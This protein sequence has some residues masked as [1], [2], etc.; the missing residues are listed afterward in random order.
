MH[1]QV[2]ESL[3]RERDLAQKYLDSVGVIILTLDAT[4]EITFINQRG[5]DVLGYKEEELIGK[6]WFD[7][8][9]PIDAREEVEGA[10]GR[11]MAGEVEPSAYDESM[12]ITKTG[13]RRIIAWHNTVLA[14]EAGQPIG[15]LRSGE[16]VTERK[17]LEREIA[18]RAEELA[19]SNTELEQFASIASHDLQEPLRMV[20]S[21]LQ[22][23]E[24]RYKGKLDSDADDFIAYAVD[25][26]NRMQA[27][28]NDLL[29]Y[30]RV[31][32]Q[33]K[34]PEPTDCNE[35]LNRV[36]INLRVVI[37]ESGAVVSR[38]ELPVI[39]ADDVQIGQVFQNLVG[40]AIKFRSDEPLRIH[41]GVKR[42][43][44]YWLFSVD[45][46]GV[47]IDQ[48][49]ADRIFRIFQRL[50]TREEYP[51]TGIGLAVC[52]RIVE[53]HGGHIWLKAKS[54]RGSTFCFTIPDKEN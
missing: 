1:K 4:G 18:R 37:E 45:D 21:F 43:N 31:D 41:V 44:G 24:Q 16:D 33:G 47:G 20:A 30:S 17:Q 2:E 52:K 19:R 35:V 27:L 48:Q 7:A 5:C 51:G 38:D 49:Y 34:P 9:I 46:N 53:R 54:G 10:L 13:A 14:N 22:L 3:R 12:V 11:L 26:A 32:T 29:T 50:H 28:I 39:M 40:N 8:C 6:N 15:V 42:K 36:L 23:L 25:G